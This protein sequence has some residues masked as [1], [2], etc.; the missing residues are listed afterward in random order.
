MMLF[1][2]L[3]SRNPSL[4]LKLNN[5]ENKLLLKISGVTSDS[6][7]VKLGF[8]F[9]A[10]KGLQYDGSNFIAEAR[11]NGSA[12]IISDKLIHEDIITI[13]KG[14]SRHIYALLSAA[15]YKNQ[16]Q[17]IIGVTGTNG[18]TSVV[19]FCR[20]IWDQ[21]GWKAVSIGTLGTRMPE[22]QTL[23]ESERSKNNLTTFDPS[24]LHKQLNDISKN[25][26]HVAIEASSHGIDQCRL[27][28]VNFSGAV[29]TNLS[30]DHM[31]YHKTKENYFSTKKR[32]FT[33]IL[34][35]NSAVAINI[36]D[37]YGILLYDEIIKLPLFILTFGKNKKADIMI[38]S[39]TQNNNSIHLEINYNNIIYSSPIGMIGDFQA[40]NV[41][42]SATICIALGM[43][44]NFVFKSLSDL[45]P[46]PGRMQ[47]VS[48]HPKDAS[49]I[50][51]YAHTPE[52]L[53]STLSSLRQNTKGRIITLFGCGGDRDKLK[54]K[55]MGN[56]A[57]QQSNQV[58]VTDDNPRNEHPSDIRKEILLGCP[59][60]IEIPD[61]NNAIKYAVSELKKN[62]LLLIAG[63]GHESLQVVGNQSLP[64]NDYNV[65]KE[66]INNL[67]NH[68]AIN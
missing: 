53:S 2:D 29:F 50:I 33:E 56:I 31:D 64:F 32:L 4:K 41:I 26:S 60:A 35:K 51:D 34:K 9:V 18:K 5:F 62:D 46:A 43:D 25:I 22:N 13:N 36:D 54:R 21:A 55:I 44:P 7:E 63:K 49:I 48:G 39:I 3:I 37:P 59:N 11:K 68:E 8:I 14:C 61:R 52:A 28:G 24:I 42:A 10:I 40:Y 17:Q 12:L 57:Q 16:P 66:T 65:A 6:K 30:H 23:N 15:Y 67:I 19:E 47:I 38:K 27:D 45:L 1:K 20:Q 58:I